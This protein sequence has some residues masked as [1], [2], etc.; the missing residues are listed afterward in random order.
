MSL[1]LEW[2]LF[3]P[4]LPLYGDFL[5]GWFTLFS[6][7]V[8]PSCASTTRL[9]DLVCGEG[10][11]LLPNQFHPLVPFSTLGSPTFMSV[12][13]HLQLFVNAFAIKRE[14]NFL[15]SAPLAHL[16]WPSI[17]QS[18]TVAAGLPHTPEAEGAWS[19]DLLQIIPDAQ[20]FTNEGSLPHKKLVALLDLCVLVV[21]V[22]HPLQTALVALIMVLLPGFSLLNKQLADS[23]LSSLLC[24]YRSSRLTPRICLKPSRESFF[25][26]SF[27]QILI[28]LLCLLLPPWRLLIMVK[29]LTLLLSPLPPPKEGSLIPQG[30]NM[31]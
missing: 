31:L 7:S 26:L 14:K 21:G 6:P 11:M 22:A 23:S 17:Y 30:R 10:W 5:S 2:R 15:M 29:C 13:E 18:L 16:T 3:A 25:L 8:F 20:M 19:Q 4:W 1:P 27:L 9:T 24:M 12:C 28:L